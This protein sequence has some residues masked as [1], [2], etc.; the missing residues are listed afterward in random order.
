MKVTL[1]VWRQRDAR[2]AGGFVR[3]TLDDVEPEVTLLEAL[4]GLTEWLTASGEPPWN[5]SAPVTI[6]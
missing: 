1:R 6:S 2:E 4:D 3:Y 5:G